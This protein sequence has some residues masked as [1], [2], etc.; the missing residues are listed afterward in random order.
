MSEPASTGE[1]KRELT[2][3]ARTVRVAAVAGF[4]MVFVLAAAITISIE[5]WGRRQP[6]D[7]TEAAPET[8]A[9]VAA[10][11]DCET[12]ISSG[13]VEVSVALPAALALKGTS[14][15]VEP[16][17][18]EVEAWDYPSERS[19]SALWLCG[20]VI[21]YVV[22]LEPTEENEALLTDLVP[23][24]EI[25]LRFTNG[26]GLLFRFSERRAV[27]AGDPEVQAQRRPQLTL[28][29]GHETWQVAKAD[30]VGDER[31]GVGSV[32]EMS[33]QVGQPTQVGDARVTVSGGYTQ[34]ENGLPPG[35]MRYL[36]EFSVENVGQVAL[37]APTFSMRLHDV[38]GNTYLVSQ[39]AS[40]A[41]EAGPLTGEIA[42]GALARATAGY[43]VPEHLPV[44]PLTWRFS[45]RPGSR[46]E[47]SIALP[48]SGQEVAEAGVGAEVAIDDAFIGHDG[49]VLVIIGRVTNLGTEPTTVEMV[50]VTLSSDAGSAELVSTAPP[51][52]WRIDPGQVQEFEL[53]YRRPPASVVV[54]EVLGYSFEIAGLE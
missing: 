22:G 36:V 15:R 11:T 13:D 45:S 17:V 16:I 38:V 48:Y 5:L 44:G 34:R 7:E 28:I 9:T 37:A 10:A 23:G 24:D 41:G 51:L 49:G 21:N 26:A 39:S 1:G 3:S 8:E 42:P 20:T 25:E 53:Q 29:V 14:Y 32:P 47:V 27:L 40:E 6:T 12:I 18:P 2:L 46:E 50:D 52:D 43:L 54:L 33:G 35:T 4:F 31:A 30:Y 19:G